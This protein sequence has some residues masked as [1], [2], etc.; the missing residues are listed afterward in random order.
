MPINEGQINL[1]PARID[2]N[3][4]IVE[5]AVVAQPFV[6][7][8]PP[9]PEPIDPPDFIYVFDEVELVVPGFAIYITQ[10]KKGTV[11]CWERKPVK[12]GNNWANAGGRH[13]VLMKVEEY[14]MICDP[15]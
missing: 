3:Q 15:L 8:P 9:V 6:A 11:E 13:K 2:W 5:N 4:F 14:E 12:I 10:N 7:P 1:Q